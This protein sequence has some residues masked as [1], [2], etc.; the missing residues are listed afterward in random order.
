MAE[1]ALRRL[2]R[3]PPPQEPPPPAPP[4]TASTDERSGAPGFLTPSQVEDFV[5]KGSR[6]LLPGRSASFPTCS[7]AAA[8][9]LVHARES[10]T[11]LTSVWMSSFGVAQELEEVAQCAVL[12]S[13]A[14]KG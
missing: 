6:G 10:L 12:S 3:G 1:Q 13:C 14:S 7:D 9:C 8:G 4:R 11:P 2:L 5:V